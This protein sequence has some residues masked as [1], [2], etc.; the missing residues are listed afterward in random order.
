MQ[1]YPHLYRTTAVADVDSTVRIC[2]TGLDDLETTSPPEFGG[3]AGYWSPE[4]LL[5]A[6]VADCLILTFRAIARASKLDWTSLECEADGTLNRVDGVTRFTHF[7]LRARLKV[8]AHVSHEKA[9]R[10]LHKSE[11]VCLITRSLTAEVHL[12]TAV[13][14]V[15]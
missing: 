13:E 10:I 8:P 12:D 11:N 3:P 4:T 1:S 5:V 14:T 6:S 9:E 15:M 7:E 2:S